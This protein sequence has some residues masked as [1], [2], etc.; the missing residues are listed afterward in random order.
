MSI[1]EIITIGFSI[2]TIIFSISA[3]LDSYKAEKIIN[4]M[5]NDIKRRERE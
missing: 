5:M 1:P 3:I 4:K 2:L